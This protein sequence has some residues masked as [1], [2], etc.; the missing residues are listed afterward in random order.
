[1]LQPTRAAEARLG[2]ELARGGVVVVRVDGGEGAAEA[3]VVGAAAEADAGGAGG[4]V[5]G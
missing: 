2:P 1:M 3:G 4:R 5:D